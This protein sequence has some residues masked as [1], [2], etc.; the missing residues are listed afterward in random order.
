MTAE[1]ESRAKD[2]LEQSRMLK[3][4]AMEWFGPQLKM[5]I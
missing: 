3:R 5:K 1:L 4:R 2:M